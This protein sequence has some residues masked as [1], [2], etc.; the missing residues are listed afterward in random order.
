MSNPPAN[1]KLS[2]VTTNQLAKPEEKKPVQKLNSTRIPYEPIEVVAKLADPIN[3]QKLI[4]PQFPL[5]DRLILSMCQCCYTKPSFAEEM[6]AEKPL[7]SYE[8]EFK[9][10]YQQKLALKIK[11]KGTGSLQLD[12]NVLHPFVRMHIIDI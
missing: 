12:P 11:I 1:I 2:T 3:V 8:D 5:S 6:L 9:E 7:F 10:Q 4:T